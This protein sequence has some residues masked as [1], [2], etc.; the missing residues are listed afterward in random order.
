MSTDL[1][2]AKRDGIRKR[3]G[4]A[5]SW[6]LDCGG[7]SLPRFSDFTV[8]GRNPPRTPRLSILKSNEA[9]GPVDRRSLYSGK[10]AGAVPLCPF[11]QLRT[12]I[13]PQPG[14]IVPP[15]PKPSPKP[16]V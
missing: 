8:L 1:N 2:G 7:A 11:H 4:S 14:E 5:D 13:P 12:A 10:D 6:R 15:T 3:L 9:F 16:P